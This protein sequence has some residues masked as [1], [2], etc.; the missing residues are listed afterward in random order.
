[1]KAARSKTRKLVVGGGFVAALLTVVLAT[2]PIWFPWVLRPLLKT[3]GVRFEAYQAI[4]YAKFALLGVYGEYEDT[5]IESARLEAPLPARWI[6]SHY[7]GDDARQP[8]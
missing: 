1:M 2:L 4:G 5:R 7:F 6:W 8:T 3:H